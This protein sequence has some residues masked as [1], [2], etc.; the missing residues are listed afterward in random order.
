MGGRGVGTFSPF[1]QSLLPARLCLWAKETK[2]TGVGVY[3]ASDMASSPLCLCGVEGDPSMEGDQQDHRTEKLDFVEPGP[4]W[5]RTHNPSASASRVLWLCTWLLH[6]CLV[7]N[8]RNY[9]F[10]VCCVHLL[11]CVH[12]CVCMHIC[13]HACMLVLCVC[14]RVL[15]VYPHTEFTLVLG[16]PAV[17]RSSWRRLVL[18]YPNL[19]E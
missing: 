13:A 2:V 8:S 10:F 7:C 4:G 1:T 12:T 11:V 19:W 6:T 9:P 3:H 5:P 18:V 16:K 14:I 15:N 17:C